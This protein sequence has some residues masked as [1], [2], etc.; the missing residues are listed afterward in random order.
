MAPS[1]A[2]FQQ[3]GTSSLDFLADLERNQLRS[4]GIF[5]KVTN[6]AG[7]PFGLLASAAPSRQNYVS[8]FYSFLFSA[9]HTP[10]Q[11]V[12]A[13]SHGERHARILCRY[14]GWFGVSTAVLMLT[15]AT[16]F[17]LCLS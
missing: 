5:L 15:L 13:A 2:S 16:F 14:A 12:S 4:D 8:N 3:D 10:T 11:Q 1:S 6:T 17:F 9:R 7:T